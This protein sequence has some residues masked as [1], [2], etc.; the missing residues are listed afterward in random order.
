MTIVI[1][2]QS[3][4]SSLQSRSFAKG[5]FIADAEMWFYLMSLAC[6]RSA[7]QPDTEFWE[8]RA[9]FRCPPS[10][11]Q[12]RMKHQ[13]HSSCT[14]CV[15]GNI[16]GPMAGE[17]RLPSVFKSSYGGINWQA[18]FGGRTFLFNASK[19]SAL[20]AEWENNIK[21][22]K[23]ECF[24]KVKSPECCK[25]IRNRKAYL[26]HFPSNGVLI[27]LPRTAWDW[28]QAPPP[29]TLTSG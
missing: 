9:R 12:F 14:S 8:E 4:P 11:P 16:P 2:L 22:P 29:G 7:W 21:D 17:E 10:S 20:S 5:F 6:G 1:C 3:V 23:S 24:D 18:R 19:S 25:T 27:L 13:S 28:L 26:K 15:H